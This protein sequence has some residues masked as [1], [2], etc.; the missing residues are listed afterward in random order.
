MQTELKRV[1]Y[2]EKLKRKQKM[3]NMLSNNGSNQAWLYLTT[4]VEII[5]KGTYFFKI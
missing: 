1:I 5:L 4:T 2:Q 3:E